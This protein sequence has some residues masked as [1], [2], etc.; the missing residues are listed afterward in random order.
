MLAALP[1][2][3]TQMEKETAPPKKSASAPASGVKLPTPV[4]EWKSADGRIMKASLL[5]FVDDK[6]AEFKREDGVAFVVALDKLSAVD[7]A[8]LKK[9]AQALGR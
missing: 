3:E 4:R 8:E 1:N 5:R 9:M 6:S 2:Y 7:Q